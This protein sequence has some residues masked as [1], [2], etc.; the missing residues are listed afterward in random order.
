MDT[1]K[2]ILFISPQPFFQWRGSPIRVNFNMLALSESGYRVDLLT[3]PV[4][5]DKQYKNV[6]IIRVANPL[7]IK[8]VPIGPSLTKIF[9]DIFLFWKGLM[10]CRNNNYV[11]IHGIE[12]AGLIAVVLAKMFKARS[13][14][15]KHSDPFSYKKGLLKNGIL[16][17]YSLVEKI[18]V[19]W[20]DGVIGT[21]EGLVSQVN[22]M[23]YSTRAFHIFDIPSS[24]EEPTEQMIATRRS[25]LVIEEGECL[26]TFVGSFALYQGVDL[27]FDTIPQVVSNSNTIRFVIVGG[28]SE[29]IAERKKILKQKGADTRVSFLGKIAPDILP[30][31]LYASDILLSPRVSGVNTPLKIL[32]YM[33]AGKPIVATDVPS[34]RLILDET[35][36]VFAKSEPEYLS[37]AILNLASNKKKQEQLGRAGRSLYETRFNF[38]NYTRQLAECYDYVLTD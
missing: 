5:E 16:Y 8:N 17:L 11:V 18:T 19:K 23:G 31:Y 36:G 38:N 33:K 29:E 22:K 9:F 34:H 37:Q 21:G 12:E 25:T 14:F 6:Q 24:L 3:L 15:E 13:I 7:R 27:M 28:K 30:E 4:G 26:V 32:D 35:T 10:L 20:C 2:K 1:R